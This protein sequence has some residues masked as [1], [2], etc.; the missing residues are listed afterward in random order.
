MEKLLL[1]TL[2]LLLCLFRDELVDFYTDIAAVGLGVHTSHLW[3]KLV[4]ALF[5]RWR[6][7]E[8]L[9]FKRLLS[10]VCLAKL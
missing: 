6:R 1:M 7:D 9:G 3:V 10:T 4:V 2:V 8:R 5:C